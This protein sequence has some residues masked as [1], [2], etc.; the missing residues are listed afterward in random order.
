MSKLSYL[1]S[2]KNGTKVYSSPLN[3]KLTRALFP[4][5]ICCKS[6]FPN[7]TRGQTIKAVRFLIKPKQK[8][9]PYDSF[10]VYVNEQF[11]SSPLNVLGAQLIGDKIETKNMD[12]YMNYVVSAH[13]KEHI[14][15]DPNAKYT[16]VSGVMKSAWKNKLFSKVTHLLDVQLHG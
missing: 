10:K 3:F 9:F 6:V 2:F 8:T 15:G 1:A 12:G 16:I 14:E 5:F 11:S 13:E 7:I 4:D